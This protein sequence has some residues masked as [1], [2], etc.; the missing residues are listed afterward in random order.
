[1][2]ASQKSAKSTLLCL[3]SGFLDHV[4]FSRVIQNLEHTAR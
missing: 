2:G 4:R 1:M 3:S